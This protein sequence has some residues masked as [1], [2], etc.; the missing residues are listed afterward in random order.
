MKNLLIAIIPGISYAAL[1]DGM[2]PISYFQFVGLMLIGILG[3][4]ILMDSINKTSKLN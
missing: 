2:A 3:F 1:I 4:S